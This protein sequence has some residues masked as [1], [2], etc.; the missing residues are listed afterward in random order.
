ML[1]LL[2]LLLDGV[3]ISDVNDT[4]TLLQLRPTAVLLLSEVLLLVL[5]GPFFAEPA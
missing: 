5:L 2:L 3:N 4:G 1:L